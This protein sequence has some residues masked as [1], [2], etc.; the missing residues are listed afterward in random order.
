MELLTCSE[1]K[2]NWIIYKRQTLLKFNLRDA[3]QGH[4]SIRER[5]NRFTMTYRYLILIYYFYSQ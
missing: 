2:S 5:N 4:L 1:Y 3:Y